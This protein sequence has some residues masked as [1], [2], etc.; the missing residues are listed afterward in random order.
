[1]ADEAALIRLM[2]QGDQAAWDAMVDCYAHDLYGVAYCRLHRDRH[3]AEEV[4][5]EVW[6]Q[7][8]RSIE[9]YDP[10][11]GQFRPW[12]LGIAN[13]CIQNHSRCVRRRLSHVPDDAP[14]DFPDT[15]P[16]W[17]PPPVQLEKVER[18]D[19]VHAAILSLPDDERQ[20]LLDKYVE[21]LSVE[22]IAERSGLTPKAIESRLSRRRNR[23][24]ALLN[25][26]FQT[27]GGGECHEPSDD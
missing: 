16:E 14:P 2:K 11:Q 5:Q 17:P 6:L 20:L 10:D 1:M 27:D 19:M 26:Y 3:A 23:F 21:G 13:H 18:D 24:R 9:R 15:S 25:S 4:T 12:L 7:A 22:E 8:V